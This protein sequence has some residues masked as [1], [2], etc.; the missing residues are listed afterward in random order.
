[1]QAYE[2][3]PISGF[4][5]SPKEKLFLSLRRGVI[6]GERSDTEITSVFAS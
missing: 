5:F 6:S 2:R 3:R 1:M 4:R